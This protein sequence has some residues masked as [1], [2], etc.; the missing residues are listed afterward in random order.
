MTEE[1]LRSMA[2]AVAASFALPSDFAP[3]RMRNEY[4]T[5]KTALFKVFEEHRPYP[6][7]G[8]GGANEQLGDDTHVEF[9][10]Q[11]LLRNRISYTRNPT[12]ATW[13]YRWCFG[14]DTAGSN[15]TTIVA[16]AGSST[17]LVPSHSIT[18]GAF[19]PHGDMY[20]A[21]NDGNR[22]GLWTDKG[23]GAPS[24]LAVEIAPTPGA[25]AAGKINAWKWSNG[26]WSVFDQ[27]TI[28]T[29]TS[30]YTFIPDESAIYAVAVDNPNVDYTVQCYTTGSCGCWGHYYSPYAVQNGNSIESVRMLGHSILLKNTSPPIYK[31]GYVTGVQPG[32]ARY[33]WDFAAQE[34]ADDPFPVV[35]DY[36]GAANT[37]PLETG[38]YG[39]IKPTEEN[40]LRLREPFDINNAIG[41]VTPVWTFAKTPILNT[42]YLVIAAQCNQQLGRAFLVRTDVGGEF[43]TGNQFLNVD[44]PRAE[45][46][47]WRDGMEALASFTQFYENP[48]HWLKILK[49]L[50]SVASI[51]GRIA[52]MFGGYGRAIGQP[53]AMAGD[54]VRGGLGG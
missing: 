32:K 4:S 33:W 18:Q 21:E 7:T 26:Q 54:I 48:T 3:L 5:E 15:I 51:G 44:R 46:A 37:F 35:R 53:V 38:I 50:G 43:E 25:G 20:F 34:P 47:E 42:A 12:N 40:D 27:R 29:G 2:G 52:S 14:R 49:T 23:P 1:G 30:A 28:T 11:D 41:T 8:Q 9:I 19:N 16:K 45:P 22:T 17:D 39:F 13:T 6:D 24:T 31:A 10:F 36:A